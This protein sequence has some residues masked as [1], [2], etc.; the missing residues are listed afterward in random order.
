V[1]GNNLGAGSRQLPAFDLIRSRKLI[2]TSSEHFLQ[3]LNSGTIS[4]NMFLCRLHNFAIG[5][6]WLSWPVLPKPHW[7]AV[8]HKDRRA[9]TADEHQTIIEREH[10]PEIRAY[11]QLLWHPGGLQ[12]DIADLTAQDIDWTAR[13]V[14][15]QRGKTNV[16]VIITFG[17]DVAALLESLPKNGPLFP[18]MARIQENHRAKMFIK[19]LKTVGITGISMHRPQA[20]QQFPLRFELATVANAAWHPRSRPANGTPCDS[21]PKGAAS[22]LKIS[23][24]GNVVLERGDRTFSHPGRCGFGPKPAACRPLPTSKSSAFLGMVYRRVLAAGTLP[25]GTRARR[26]PA[27]VDRVSKLPE[28][29]SIALP[30]R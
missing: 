2:E 10:N 27:V 22:S 20:R 24:D 1:C 8:R 3:V 4:T 18:R 17:E 7:P 15:Y 14:S 26:S 25:F 11:S 28:T 13:T 5:M 16:P 29:P 21:R 12:T 6:H 9:I 23:F 19:R 30:L